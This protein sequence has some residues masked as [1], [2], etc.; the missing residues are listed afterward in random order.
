MGG[1]LARLVNPWP[2]PRSSLRIRLSFQDGPRILS[3]GTHETGR[4][5]T[6]ERIGRSLPRSYG[7]GLRADEYYHFKIMNFGRPWAGYGC[8]QCFDFSCQM[9]VSL[10]SKFI[11]LAFKLVGRS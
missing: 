6:D 10:L 3:Y 8:Q 2:P 1:S 4:A 5:D 7:A 11:E 9:Q